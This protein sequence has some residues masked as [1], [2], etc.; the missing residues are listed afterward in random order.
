ML[1]YIP[2]LSILGSLEFINLIDVDI[3]F[4]NKKAIMII[5]SDF[6]LFRHL[7]GGHYS[8]C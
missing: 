1:L 6:Y 4:G 8:R 3:L 5:V 7:Q 2:R